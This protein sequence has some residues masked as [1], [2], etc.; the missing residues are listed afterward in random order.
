M[1]FTKLKKKFKNKLV[2]HW[3]KLQF[4]KALP[5]LGLNVYNLIWARNFSARSS[6][7][8]KVGLGTFPSMSAGL[9]NLDSYDDWLFG[10]SANGPVHR[11]PITWHGR[12]R[13]LASVISSGGPRFESLSECYQ[14][15]FDFEKDLLKWRQNCSK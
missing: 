10:F 8:P 12:R 7:H 13:C 14:S 15:N 3:L 11:K 5:M 1:N 9:R 6:S 4:L 2:L